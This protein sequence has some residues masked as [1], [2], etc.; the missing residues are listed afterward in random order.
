MSLFRLILALGLACAAAAPPSA[1]AAD[2][3]VGC[4][5]GE[6]CTL[7][8]PQF[9]CKDFSDIKH[10]ID[11][12]VDVDRDAAEK[13]IDDQVATGECTRFH[14]G[15]KLKLLRYL[16]L[17]RLEVRRPNDVQTFIILLK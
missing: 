14:T 12:Y 9:G 5:M 3:T 1:R 8:G 4:E 17:R 16:G 11:I 2:K 10:W 13:Y 7:Q 15:D 6:V